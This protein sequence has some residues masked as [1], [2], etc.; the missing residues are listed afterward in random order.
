[1]FVGVN[2][3]VARVYDDLDQ[4]GPDSNTVSVTFQDA[5]LRA[6]TRVSLT[7]NFAKRG[8]NPGQTLTWPVE[9]SGGLG[10]YAFS[11]EWGDGKEPDLFTVAFPGSLDLTHVYDQPGVYRVIV[12]AVDANG[13]AAFLQLVAVANGPLSQDANAGQDADSGGFVTTRTRVIWWPAAAL[14]PFVIS[15]FWLGKRYML[16]VMKKRIERGEH[17]FGDV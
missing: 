17:P 8:A 2:E 10:P 15:T 7:S 12:K 4:P 13:V 1:L 16:F 11:V 6:P 3:L 5:L 9:L 14:V